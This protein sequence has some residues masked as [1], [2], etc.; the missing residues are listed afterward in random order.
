[1][2]KSFEIFKPIFKAGSDRVNET[3]QESKFWKEIKKWLCIAFSE[4]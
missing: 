2:G 3:Y 1:M 4:K